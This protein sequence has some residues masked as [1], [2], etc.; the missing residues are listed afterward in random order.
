MNYFEANPKNNP[1]VLTITTLFRYF[2]NLLTYHYQKKTTPNTQ[3]MARSLGVHPFFMKDYIDGG[4]IYNAMKCATTISL[5]R[6]YDMKSKGV[7]NANISDGELL[8][9]LIFKIMH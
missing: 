1:L 9:E 4:K 5:L 6:E 7:G 3:E 2:L 8:K